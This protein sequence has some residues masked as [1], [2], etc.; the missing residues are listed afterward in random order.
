MQTHTHEN[1]AGI[2]L[3]DPTG[4]IKLQS[5]NQ[6]TYC[7]IPRDSYIKRNGCDYFL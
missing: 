1:T 5:P 7:N 2:I 3:I 6:W 4:W